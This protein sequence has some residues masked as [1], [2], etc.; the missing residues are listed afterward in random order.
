M[1]YDVSFKFLFEKCAP[2]II[3][4][5]VGIPVVE[6]D[7]VEPL[8]TETVSLRRS[9]AAFRVTD[10]NGNQEI[11]LL[12]IQTNWEEDVPKRL[13]EYRSRY[14]VKCKE[15]ITSCVLLLK[16]TSGAVG[17]YEDNEISYRF[18]LIRVYEFDAEKIISS[19]VTCLLP[20]VPIM[21]HGLDL[22]PGADQLVY[23]S[24]LPLQDKVDLLSAMTAFTGLVSKELAQELFSRRRDLIMESYA[25]ELFKK[26]GFD[27]GKKEGTTITAQ[28]DIIKIIQVRLGL[29]SGS[30]ETTIHSLDEPEK[31]SQ[32]LVLAATVDSLQR[33]E[34][35]L[36][37][38][39]KRPS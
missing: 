4:Q 2:Q 7:S 34:S 6:S 24:P 37:Q 38:I 8:P 33:F 22:L 12:E 28:E 21:R 27:E 36:E 9:D 39:V 13:L 17:H 16:P 29:I 19:G 20:L 1:Q 5:L 3:R 15:K 26:E 14:L 11:V 35:E 18:R 32:L 23:E 31:L 25:Y 30:M 10:E